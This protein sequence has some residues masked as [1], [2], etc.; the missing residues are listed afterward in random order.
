M[1]QYCFHFINGNPLINAVIVDLSDLDAAK[2]EVAKFVG[3]VLMSE[4]PTNNPFSVD[5]LFRTQ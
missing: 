4:Q 5:S 3:A 1:P 2:A